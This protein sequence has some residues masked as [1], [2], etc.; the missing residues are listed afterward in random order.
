MTKKILK[1][2]LKYIVLLTDVELNFH[3]ELEKLLG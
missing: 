1:I 2:I 3:V